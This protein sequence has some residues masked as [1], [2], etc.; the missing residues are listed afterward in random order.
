MRRLQRHVVL[1]PDQA[2]TVALWIIMAWA[3]AGAA[4]YSPI[5]MATSAEANS[6]KSTLGITFDDPTGKAQ[7]DPVRR[8]SSTRGRRFRARC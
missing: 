4:I 7:R 3:H 6:G 2:L 8:L 1:T 5:L